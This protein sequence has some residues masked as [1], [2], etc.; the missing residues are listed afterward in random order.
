M[1][2]ALPW[3]FLDFA[4]G[5]SLSS[6]SSIRTVPVYSWDF[7]TVSGSLAETL[8]STHFDAHSIACG[9]DAVFLPIHE[10]TLPE[11]KAWMVKT[12]KTALLENLSYHDAGLGGELNLSE[13]M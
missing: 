6:D 13:G 10:P 12:F 8:E 2:G 7:A 5:N 3:L 4:K 9:L 1:N 11:N